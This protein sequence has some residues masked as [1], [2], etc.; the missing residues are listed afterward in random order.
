LP[1]AEWGA[2]ADFRQILDHRALMLNDPIGIL[3]RPQLGR[4]YV[5]T[6]DAGRAKPAYP[7]LFKLARIWTP[8]AS[9]TQN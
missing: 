6:L 4:A 5:L 3:A 2:A 9:F 1:K 7:G 8:A